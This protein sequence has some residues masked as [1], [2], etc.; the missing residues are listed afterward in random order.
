MVERRTGEKAGMSGMRLVDE[1]RKAK[2]VFV[3]GNGGS[4]A[5]AIHIVND[6]VAAGVKAQALPADIATLTAQAN[7]YGY[8]T[9]FSAQLRVL[10]EPSDLLVVLSG[11]G[12]SPNILAAL[13]AANDIG[14][15]SVAVVGAYNENTPAETLATHTIRLGLDMQAAEEHQLMLGHQVWRELR[16]L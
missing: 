7:D 15:V 5:N 11:S 6:W 3:A 10:A 8:A 4:A 12:Q 16:A 9:V 13:A 1:I 14:M 2:R